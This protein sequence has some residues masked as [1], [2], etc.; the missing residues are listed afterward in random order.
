MNGSL[1]EAS[2]VVLSPMTAVK[3]KETDKYFI[4]ADAGTRPKLGP[5]RPL[6]GGVEVGYRKWDIKGGRGE[7]RFALIYRE[8]GNGC[9][10]FYSSIIH[11]C[12]LENVFIAFVFRVRSLF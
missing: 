9:V 5:G 11:I 4:A 3:V 8:T 1:S 2:L 10:G 7:Y 12:T 6:V